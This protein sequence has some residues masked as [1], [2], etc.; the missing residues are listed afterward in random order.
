MT[1]S[2]WGWCR[3]CQELM[4]AANWVR[5]LPRGFRGC[6]EAVWAVRRVLGLPG[7]SRGCQEDVEV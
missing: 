5:G 4:E 6:Q 7:G 2:C 3:D 1:V